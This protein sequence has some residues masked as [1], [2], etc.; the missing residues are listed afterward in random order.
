MRNFLLLWL[1]LSLGACSAQPA[2]PREVSVQAEPLTSVTPPPSTATPIIIPTFPPTATTVPSPTP[3][4][5]AVPPCT[6]VTGTITST[7]IPSPLTGPITTRIYLPPCYAQSKARYPVLYLLHG[8]GFTEDQW[9]RLGVATAADELIATDTI[10]PLIIVMP[11]APSSDRWDEALALTVVPYVDT[12]FRTVSERAARALGGLSRGGGWAVHI[13]LQF[14][15]M[16]GRL[17][18]HSP[19]VFYGDE[20]K[21]LNWG[22]AI[23]KAGGP[24]PAIYIDVGEGDRDGQSAAWLDQVFTYFNWKQTFIVQ[25]GGHSEK[26]W[27]QHVRDYLRFYAAD[28]RGQKFDAPETFTQPDDHQ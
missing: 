15:E 17:G 18:L 22:R 4:P 12:T 9:E 14:P 26:Y 19:A 23:F 3:A 2:A 27:S 25:P 1:S 10:A 13:G 7:S 21:L 16:F 28:W 24:A 6:D 8:K 11:R 20:G 5:T